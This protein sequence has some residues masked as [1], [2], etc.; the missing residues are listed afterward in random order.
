MHIVKTTCSLWRHSLSLRC[1]VPENLNSSSELRS[2]ADDNSKNA[3]R[4]QEPEPQDRP[5]VVVYKVWPPPADGTL[6][7][8]RHRKNKLSKPNADVILPY[9]QRIPFSQ[10]ASSRTCKGPAPQAMGAGATG[11]VHSRL[12]NTSKKSHISAPEEKMR[13]ISLQSSYEQAPSWLLI[14]TKSRC[15]YHDLVGGLFTL[16]ANT[17]KMHVLPAFTSEQKRWMNPQACA[18]VAQHYSWNKHSKDQY[19]KS[20]KLYKKPWEKEKLCY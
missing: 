4:L 6:P 17:S 7:R 9:S 14:K 12:F 18:M 1:R 16:R 15:S 5:R 8:P 20:S 11:T 13:H 10:G 19:G 2:Q 3:L